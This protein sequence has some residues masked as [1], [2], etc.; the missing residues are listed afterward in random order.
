MNARRTVRLAVIMG[1]VLTC[2]GGTWAQTRTTSAITGTVK[3]QDGGAVVGA[4]VTIES[5][6][7]IGGA[8]SQ[9]TNEQG[10]FRFPEI[11]PGTYTVTVVMP[12]YK[13]LRR[14]DVR[15]PVGISL[16]LPTSIVPF[17]G[18][19]TVVVTG[20]PPAIDVKS[21]ETTNVLSNEV[22][23]NIPASQFQPDTLNLA[24]GI[25]QTVAWG[26]AEDT[27]VAWQI[28]GVDTSDP[29]AGSAWSFVNY[30]I[31]D[32]VELAGLGAPAEYGGFTGVVF[33][34]TTKS[35]G[36]DVHGL[37][38]FYFSNDSLTFSNDAP[39]GL[40]PTVE[41][42]I[43]T[44]VNAGGPF[45]KDKLWWYVSGQYYNQVTNE[46]GPDRNEKSPRAFGKISWQ[47]NPNNNFD[48]WLEWDRFDVT[49]RGGDSITP[50][51]A[52]VKETAPEYVWNFAW[53]SVL[54]KNTILD[55]TLQGYTGYYYLDPTS[56]Y[57]LPGLY[58]GEAGV[59]QQNST[60]YYLADRD[61]NQIN[62][63]IAKHVS[64]WGGN[65]DFKFGTEIE[66]STLRSRY[67]Y[68]TGSKFYNN[69]VGDDPGIPGY[70]PYT[71][72]YDTEYTGGSYDIHATN[73]RLSLY[74]QD[75][76]QITPLFTINPGV[77][78]D[79][80]QGRVPEMG[81]VY[82]Y[83]AIAPRLGMAWNVTGDNRN[84][85]KAHVGRYY[86]GAH[87]TYYY[88][89]APDAFE[90]SQIITHWHS[91]IDEP[92][93]VRTKRYAIDPDLKQPYMDQY[94]LGYDRALPWS[95]VFSVTGIYRKW[96]QFVETVAQNPV[97]VPVTGEV[98][99]CAD[100][101]CTAYVSTGQTVQMFDWL[102]ADTDTLLV[103][104]PS[105]LERTYK[106]VMLTLTKNFRDN[107]QGT[108]AYVY[109]KAE[110]TIDNIG[111]TGNQEIG[112]IDSGP[113]SYLDTPNSKVNWDGKL[114]HDPTHQLKLQGTY[115]VAPASLWLSANWTYYSG[116]TYTRQSECL[117][118]DDD[119][120]PNTPLD[121]H[122]FPQRDV[123]GKVRFFSEARGSHRL[124]SYNEI[125]ARVEWKPSFGKRGRFG[126]IADVFNLLN[127]SQVTAR[128]VRD[129]G[130]FDLTTTHNIGRNVR[131]GVRYEF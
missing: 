27:G 14:E 103:T 100:A 125:N 70:D 13:T 45:I 54:S 31:I 88:W 34:S 75:D 76:W 57:N 89:V 121:C 107:W 10:R 11:A 124:P 64:D 36:N 19:E 26:G 110:G 53:K 94:T 18:E 87:G 129:D 108:A 59:F 1:L 101:D 111:F 25:N 118:T 112:G 49:G 41:K 106:G 24:P 91:G 85:I 29:E 40:N 73:E 79:F 83:T 126:V 86:A 22:L 123:T 80:I 33:N 3:G 104:N 119:G 61:R 2:A 78:V 55:V 16:D 105:G 39:A 65:H 58:D 50:L 66:R 81:K 8:R 56:G 98:G 23:Q 32:Q 4:T 28:D 44:T 72:R 43:N 96:K 82:D 46:G 47:I 20:E 117:L 60:Y 67:G 93:A 6:Q 116:D 92:G 12:G 84:L 42:Y 128:H 114:I 120:D 9:V 37:A 69:Y 71:E 68:P 127:H 51:E 113:S 74:A 21:P 131:L 17:A 48:A 109:S 52:T 35:G 77:R 115:V 90:D 122:V 63:S 38:D 130:D 62:A 5:P 95:M 7:L 99:I 15:L 30:N 97:Y 102:N